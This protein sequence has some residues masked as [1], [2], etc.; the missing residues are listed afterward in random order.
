MWKRR[1][2]QQGDGRSRCLL[3]D[4]E[5][6]MDLFQAL[7]RTWTVVIF[8]CTS[9]AHLHFSTLMGH[10]IDNNLFMATFIRVSYSNFISKISSTFSRARFMFVL[11]IEMQDRYRYF[12]PFGLLDNAAIELSRLLML[13]SCAWIGTVKGQ[14][15]V[16]SPDT[17]Y[18]NSHLKWPLEA[19]GGLI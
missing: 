8:Q 5:P 14:S 15:V 12:K 9:L 17:V 6:S 3:C 10:N 19:V 18:L 11:W 13:L 7:V 1:R 2:F 4:Y 16:Q